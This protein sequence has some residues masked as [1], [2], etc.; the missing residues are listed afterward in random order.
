MVSQISKRKLSVSSK[1]QILKDGC[2]VLRHE[3]EVVSRLSRRLNTDFSTAIEL[4]VGNQGNV[5]LTG[6]GKAG[7][8]AQKIAATLASTGTTSH[9]LHPAEAV[10]GDLGRVQANDV[11]VVL[12]HSGETEDIL[13]LLPSVCA[14][15]VP[16]I[17]ITSYK[18]SSLGKAATVVLEL[19]AIEEAD[20][21]G[22]A[23]SSSTTAMLALG[24]ALALVTSQQRGFG[25]QDFAALHPAGSLGRRLAKVEDIMRPLAECRIA[26][27]QDSVREILVTLGQAGR[28]T[29]AIMLVDDKGILTGVF[30]D[31]DLARLLENGDDASLDLPVSNV[32]TRSPSKTSRGRL[33]SQAVEHLIRKKISELPVVDE[34]SRPIG[35]IDITDVV[36]YLPKQSEDANSLAPTTSATQDKA[37]SKNTTDS[38]DSSAANPNHQRKT[39]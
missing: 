35:I 12:S 11:L 32:M 9:F 29:G 25:A 7:L 1:L 26:L 39:A 19:G 30:T 23:P 24:D 33:I 34:L 8:V 28:R 27:D 18:S 38:E 14:W 20:S 22:L 5:I 16:V 4:L 15:K 13:R 6:M 3:A 21:L 37:V 36:A 17:A 10:H 31:S 2:D